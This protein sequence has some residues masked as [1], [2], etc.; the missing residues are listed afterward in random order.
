[1][2]ACGGYKRAALAGRGK[3]MTARARGGCTGRPGDKPVRLCR[4]V[5]PSMLLAGG[6]HVESSRPLPRRR[7]VSAQPLPR[8]PHVFWSSAAA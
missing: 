6:G 1:M 4:T 3:G 8:P 5:F 7:H 2:K